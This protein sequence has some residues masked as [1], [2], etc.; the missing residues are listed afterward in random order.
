MSQ[1]SSKLVELDLSHQRDPLHQPNHQLPDIGVADRFVLWR[2]NRMARRALRAAGD[3]NL[4]LDLSSC[5]GTYWALL[6]S[7]PNRLVLAAYSSAEQLAQ[8]QENHSVGIP[9]QVCALQSTASAIQL[10]ENA[11]DSIFCMHLLQQVESADQRLALLRELHR[12]TRDTVILSLW[13]DGK[14]AWKPLRFLLREGHGM[15][16]QVVAKEQ[17]E[18]EFRSVGF[19]ILTHM[20]LAPGYATWRIYVLRKES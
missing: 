7:H 15:C 4:V 17:I 3:P 2:K 14:A 13:I 11:V 9:E 10:G 20:D 8:A 1:T 5:V 12:V 16:R 6:T 19:Q 18:T